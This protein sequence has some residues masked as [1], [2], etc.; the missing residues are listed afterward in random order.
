MHRLPQKP[1]QI[2]SFWQCQPEQQCVTHSSVRFAFG[3]VLS[4]T[5]ERHLSLVL[6]PH[7]A[8]D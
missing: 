3:D 1:V 2:C 6:E 5:R 7:H 8:L 4:A